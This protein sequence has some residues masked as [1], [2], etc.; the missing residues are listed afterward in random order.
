M[1]SSKSRQPRTSVRLLHL[2][3]VLGLALTYAVPLA[4]SVSVASPRPTLDRPAGKQSFASNAQTLAFAPEADAWVEESN[5]AENHG[6]APMLEVDAR[7]VTESYLRFRIS[8]VTGAVTRT[9]LR[10]YAT[11]RTDDGPAVYGAGSSWTEEEITWNTRPARTTDA[12][13]DMGLFE[14]NTWVEYDITSLVIADGVYSFALVATSTDGADFESREGENPP[15]LIVTF[16]SASSPL[17]S[18][19]PLPESDGEGAIL[20]GAGDIAACNEDGDEATAELLDTIPGTVFTTGDNVYGSGGPGEYANCYDPTWG[21]HKDRTRPSAG[22]HDYYTDGASG[23]FGYF[24]E[25]AG[26]PKEGY[27]SYDL[28]TWHI[29]VLNSNCDEIGGCDAGS[30][31]EQWLRAD[32]A[33]HPATCTLAYWHHP[34]FSSGAKHGSDDDV[35]PLWEALY[36]AGAEVVLV[37]HEHQYERFAPQDPNGALD[38]GRGIR[39]IVIGT[40]G[41]ELYGFGPIEANSE[42]RNADT[43]GVLQLTLGEGRYTWEFIPVAGKDFTDRG[44]GSCHE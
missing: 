38:P 22:N 28:G 26:D 15:Q 12:A 35:L 43:F 31:Q 3:L 39:Q 34:L 44:T 36:D 7:P 40:G 9:T 21:R 5:P 11:N 10:L 20:V 2:T 1:S 6:S 42:A 8:G 17:P 37:G 32:L 25:A 41:K 33:A 16:D 29:V 19:T 4:V 24:D 23:Y 13:G 14:I 30:P 27:Y 18:S